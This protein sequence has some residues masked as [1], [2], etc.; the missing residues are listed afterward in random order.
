MFTRRFAAGQTIFSEGDASDVAYVIR[1]GRAEVLK[2]TP[3]G[4]LRL[5]VLGPGD[6]LGEMGLLDERPRSATAVALDAVVADS[7]SPTEFVRQLLH[8]PAKSM[9]LLSALF[10]RLRAMN[11]L[12]S[13][14]VSHARTA[15][16]PVARLVPLTEETR[17]VL[18]ENGIEVERYPFRVGRVPDSREAEALSFN[19][20]QI[21]DREP[22]LLSLNHFAL[23]LAAD[24]IMVRDRGSQHGTLVNG[25]R[26]GAHGQRDALPIAK[27]ENEVVAGAPGALLHRRESPFRFKIV[28][29]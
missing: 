18:P 27:G 21:A 8:E 1:S 6:V 28:V 24:A 11:R 12:L 14:Q 15:P 13:E 16:I 2:E 29:D 4:Q 26:I 23:E 10:E 19:E 20:I 17:A 5:A 9:R 3:E 22:Y 25:V 7:V